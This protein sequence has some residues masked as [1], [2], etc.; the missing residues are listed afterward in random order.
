MMAVG[1]GMM[2]EHES[3]ARFCCYEQLYLSGFSVSLVRDVLKWNMFKYSKVPIEGLRCL[4]WWVR[5]GLKV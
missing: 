1:I 4:F 5:I 3:F 2:S